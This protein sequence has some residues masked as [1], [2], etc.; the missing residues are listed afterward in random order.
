MPQILTFVQG[1][2]WSDPKGFLVIRGTLDTICQF[3]KGRTGSIYS[4]NSDSCGCC[5]EEILRF[6]VED[7]VLVPQPTIPHE[8]T[9]L[10]ELAAH[11]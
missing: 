5:S 3:L 1:D 4:E 10:E 2:V 7:G 9:P 8:S 11:F 6:K